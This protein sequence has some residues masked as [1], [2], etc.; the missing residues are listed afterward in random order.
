MSALSTPDPE[1]RNAFYGA[2]FG[3]ETDSF[4]PMTLWRLPGF[5]GGEPA[6]PVP[7][8]LVAVGQPGDDAAA[9]RSTSGSTTPTPPRSEP[10]SSAAP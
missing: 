3:W 2:V 1:A 9:G 8:D 7:R 10:P 5:V 6:Q 4:G